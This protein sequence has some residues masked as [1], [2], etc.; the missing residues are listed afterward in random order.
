[1]SDSGLALTSGSILIPYAMKLRW[2]V[3]MG[4]GMSSTENELAL[5]QW[6]I[7]ICALLKFY[8]EVR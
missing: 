5:C 6:L 8:A 4:G 1:M 3:Y 7:Q 2:G